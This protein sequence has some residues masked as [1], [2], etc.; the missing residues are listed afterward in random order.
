MSEE[1]IVN[2]SGVISVEQAVASLS[3]LD[4]RHDILQLFS[5]RKGYV[6][7]NVGRVALIF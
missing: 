2:C 6:Y 3:H 7:T 1:K 4:R 5:G